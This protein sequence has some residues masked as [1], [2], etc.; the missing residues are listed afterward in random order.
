VARSKKNL[1]VSLL[2]K[3]KIKSLSQGT[4]FSLKNLVFDCLAEGRENVQ[5][6]IW[7]FYPE[8]ASKGVKYAIVLNQSCDIEISHIKTS[9]LIV[10]LLEPIGKC[11]SDVF[12]KDYRNKNIIMVL[13][14]KETEVHISSKQQIKSQISQNLRLL[15]N[16]NHEKFFFISLGSLDKNDY[17][18]VNLSKMIPIKSSH[19]SSI[20]NK[21]KYQLCNKFDEKLGWKLASLFGR[22]GTDDFNEVYFDYFADQFIKPAQAYFN[23]TYKNL[24]ILNNHDSLGTI[25]NI[26]NNKKL[27]PED[28][29][30]RLSQIIEQ[31]GKQ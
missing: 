9:H 24:I 4:I 13:K 22:V 26:V 1:H 20:L 5:S 18:I 7:D 10:A 3:K 11:F 31:D 21:A 12:S 29:N 27:S 8:L 17:Y 23:K 19:Y 25:K 30:T 16:N 6:T 2:D 28:L 14:E 15:F